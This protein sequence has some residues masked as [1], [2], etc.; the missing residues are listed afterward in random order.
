MMRNWRLTGLE[1][2]ALWGAMRESGALPGPFILTCRIPLYRDYLEAK[3][4]ALAEVRARL[5]G[6]IE[7]VLDIVAKPD[8]R[9]VANGVDLIADGARTRLHAARRGSNAY[10]LEQA[11]REPG[12]D[13]GE[14]VVWEHGV[15][16]LGAAVVSRIPA[17]GAGRLRNV[18]LSTHIEAG[19]DQEYG[20]YLT[21]EPVEDPAWYSSEK[22]LRTPVTN[23]G[24]IFI[25]QG[26][27]RFGSGHA[28]RRVLEWRDLHDDGRY[29]I[30]RHGNPVAFGV[31]TSGF[32]ARVD[33]ELVEVVRA[34]KDERR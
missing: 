33:G 15:T 16:E 12:E 20:R 8:I 32:T 4:I 27:S 28:A 14:F 2:A 26:V 11:S 22:F 23:I 6:S 34:I 13:G 9:I 3:R 18:D 30:A 1:F 24:T 25:G 17:A 31:D 7:E 29:V 19:M 10:L 5:G 21:R